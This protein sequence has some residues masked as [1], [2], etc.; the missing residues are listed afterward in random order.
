MYDDLILVILPNIHNPCINYA[1]PLNPMINNLICM[2]VGIIKW[3]QNEN[4]TRSYY[5]KLRDRLDVPEK[6]TTQ[7]HLT[8]PLDLHRQLSATVGG[9]TRQTSEI[10]SIGIFQMGAIFMPSQ[11]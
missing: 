5:S 9:P 10:S 6:S 3:F 1:T 2:L 7:S 8:V 11:K 4:T